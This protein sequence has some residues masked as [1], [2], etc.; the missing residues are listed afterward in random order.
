MNNRK[1][2]MALR[3]IL[4][5]LT[6]FTVLAP[7]VFAA[8]VGERVGGSVTSNVNALIPAALA[9]IGL[10]FLITRDW[11]KMASAFAITLIVAIFMNWT[12]VQ[13]I[14]SKIYNSF[15]A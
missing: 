13:S 14:A 15:I 1:N 9:C 11:F 12:W 6:I 7:A 10:Y 5:S 4:L 8:G 2:Q 3:I